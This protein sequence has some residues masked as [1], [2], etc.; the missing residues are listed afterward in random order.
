MG[1]KFGFLSIVDF[2]ATIWYI[3]APNVQCVVIHR[4]HHVWSLFLEW[5]LESFFG[6]KFGVIYRFMIYYL[7]LHHFCLFTSAIYFNVVNTSNNTFN[8]KKIVMTIFVNETKCIFEKNYVFCHS[9]VLSPYFSEYT[10]DEPLKIKFR[11]P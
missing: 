11:S 2:G 5:S 4:C 9:D 8:R 6:V 3:L 10:N 7:S 1:D